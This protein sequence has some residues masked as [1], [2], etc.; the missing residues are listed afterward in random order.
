MTLKFLMMFVVLTV[1]TFTGDAQKLK[2]MRKGAPPVDVTKRVS[3]VKSDYSLEQFT[4]KWQEISRRRSK[5]NSS[6]SFKDTLF[7]NFSANGEVLS[8]DGVNMSMSG[9]AAIEPGNILVAAADVFTIRSMTNNQV[10]LDDGEYLHTLIRKKDFWHEGLPTNAIIPEK[11]TTPVLI[12]ASILLGKWSVYRR[13]AKPGTEGRTLIKMLDVKNSKNSTEAT[14]EITFYK[15]EKSE[16][17]PFTL[18]LEGKKM[19][20]STQKNT[21]SLNVFKADGKELVFGDD[22][23]IYYC[24]LLY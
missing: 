6:L 2:V 7:Y 21:W 18:T 23:L 16:T 12:D 3:P 15:T 1:I 4:G 14:G 19:N 9:Q 17:L 11:F 20:I 5:K 22:I 13:D 10:V 24:K 8:R